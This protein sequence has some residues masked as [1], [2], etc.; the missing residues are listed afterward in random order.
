M[1]NQFW[2]MIANI[3]N[4]QLAKRSFIYQK[5]K[6][7]CESFLRILWNEDF[8]V[9]YKLS[10]K[11]EGSIKI[12]LKYVDNEKPAINDI[13]LITKPGRR[14]SYSI[15]QIWKIDSNK[16]FLIFSTNKGLQTIEGCKKLKVGGEPFIIIN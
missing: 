2:N 14:V 12:F 8:I 7:L 15:K 5:R 13:K 3:R 1:K 9:G 4:G 16:N 11:N 6:K 10:K